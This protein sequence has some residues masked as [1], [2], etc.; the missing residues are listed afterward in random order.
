[1]LLSMQASREQ[2]RVSQLE[3]PALETPNVQISNVQEDEAVKE[4]IG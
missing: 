4:G 1:M 3:G 2:M